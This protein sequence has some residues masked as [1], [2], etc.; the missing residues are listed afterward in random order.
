MCILYLEHIL[1]GAWIAEKLG[2]LM[3]RSPVISKAS[4]T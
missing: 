2:E 4:W 3:I 1:V